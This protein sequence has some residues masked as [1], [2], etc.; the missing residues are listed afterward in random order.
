MQRVDEQARAV[1]M[2]VRDIADGQDGIEGFDKLREF[3]DYQ[4]EEIGKLRAEL[5]VQIRQDDPASS[6]AA[7][8]PRQGGSR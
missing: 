4:N 5:S 3:V 7:P 2:W 8:R 6:S 1:P